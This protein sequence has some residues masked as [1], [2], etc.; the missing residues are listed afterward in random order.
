MATFES[1]QKMYDV[2]GELF[3]T[4][5]ENEDVAEKFLDAKLTILFNRTRQAAITTELIEVVSGKEAMK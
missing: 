2:L 3:R 5:M 4:L 1:T